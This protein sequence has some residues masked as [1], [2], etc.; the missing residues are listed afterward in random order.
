MFYLAQS[1]LQVHEVSWEKD[2]S[3]KFGNEQPARRFSSRVI[4][5]AGRVLDKIGDGL[6]H[7]GMKLKANHNLDRRTLI[8]TGK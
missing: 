7:L 3:S 6:I 2:L 4:A 8:P 1:M 5:M